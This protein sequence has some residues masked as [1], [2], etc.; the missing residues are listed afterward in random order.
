MIRGIIFDLGLTL[1]NFTGDEKEA[2]EQGK[3]E[4]LAYLQQSALNI[5]DD[6]FL[7]AFSTQLDRSFRLRL[8]DHVERPTE[9]IFQNVMT[10]LGYPDLLSDFVSQAMQSYYAPSEDHWVLMSETKEVLD[11]LQGEGFRLALLSNAGNEQNVRRLIKKANIEHYFEVILVSAHEGM[12][13]PDQSLYQKIIELWNLS[14][15]Q[16]AMIGDSLE[17][18]IVGA[19]QAGMCTI[20]LMENVNTTENHRLAENIEPDHIAGR[21]GDIPDLIKTLSQ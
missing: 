4:I 6:K 5:E 8:E 14:A 16:I 9:I 21:L 11:S 7:E 1:L 19:K 2:I 20:W 13:K 3:K 15:E 10:D 18:D 17:Q 12:R